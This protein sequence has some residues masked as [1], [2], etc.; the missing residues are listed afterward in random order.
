MITSRNGNNYQFKNEKGMALALVLIFT[1]ILLILGTAVMNYAVNESLITGYN[2]ND[3]R[4]YYIVEAGLETGVAVLNDDFLA[5]NHLN[6]AVAEGTFTVNFFDEYE[7][8]SESHLDFPHEDYYLNQDE[9]RFIRSIGT[10]GEHSKVMTAAVIQD[11][12]GQ[13]H[14]IR[15]YAI[16]PYH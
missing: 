1:A 16:L 14:V 6:N 3:I 11:E 15:W 8:Y 7:H 9:V 13:V 4:L 2:K 12:D 5:E 10:L